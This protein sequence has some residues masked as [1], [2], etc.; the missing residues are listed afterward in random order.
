MKALELERILSQRLDNAAD[1]VEAEQEKMRARAGRRTYELGKAEGELEG[2]LVALAMLE[3]E[4]H[5]LY[6]GTK[7]WRARLEER[8]SS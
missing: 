3:Q 4:E 1:R 6:S 2:M 8:R 5:R 7:K